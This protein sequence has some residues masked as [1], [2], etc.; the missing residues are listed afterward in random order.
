MPFFFSN[1][2]FTWDVNLFTR[3][4]LVKREN[5]KQ[6]RISQGY[7]LLLLEGN[8]EHQGPHFLS[9]SLISMCKI[10]HQ[11]VQAFGFPHR[12]PPSQHTHTLY[13]HTLTLFLKLKVNWIPQRHST[14]LCRKFS[15]YSPPPSRI[16]E[17]MAII[18]F[19]GFVVRVAGPAGWMAGLVAL[20]SRAI[21]AQ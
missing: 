10:Q 16:S 1:W 15:L 4:P 7:A 14:A 9:L 2:P 11:V 18:I 20:C 21:H 17:A 12:A 3:Q 13:T 8:H 19:R 6:Q 5:Y